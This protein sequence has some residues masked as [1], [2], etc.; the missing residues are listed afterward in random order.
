MMEGRRLQDVITTLRG[1]TAQRWALGGLAV[2]A[3]VV[4]LATTVA[5]TDQP[6]GWFA[7]FVISLAVISA[8]QPGWNTSA[9]VIALVV[10]EWLATTDEVTDGRAV[11]V[12]SCLFVFH[13]SLALI[14]VTPHTTSA[15]GTVVRVWALRSAFVV[16]ATWAVWLLVQIGEQRDAAGDPLLTL[17]ALAAVGAAAFVLRRRA[18]GDHHR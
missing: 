1:T 7:L 15:P 5:G 10:I 13:A 11:V 8:I 14:A 3:I 9:T 6:F 18:V 16:A 2:T 17:T 4:A 12:A